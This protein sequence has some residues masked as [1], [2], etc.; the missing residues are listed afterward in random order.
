MESLQEFFPGLTRLLNFIFII[1]TIQSS[2]LILSEQHI[3]KSAKIQVGK[4]TSYIWVV[5][6]GSMIKIGNN[7]VVARK[8]YLDGRTGYID[9]HNNVSIAPEA[10]IVSM[11]HDVNSSSFDSVIKHY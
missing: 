11:S 2:H 6:S 9:I 7:C 5:F 8:C 10:Y 3:S 1:V 4:D